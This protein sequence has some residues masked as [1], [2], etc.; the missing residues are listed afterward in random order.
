MK[1]KVKVMDMNSRT[2]YFMF[3]T[4]MLII[5]TIGIF[6]RY[7]PLSS[8]ALAFARGLLGAL[9]LCVFVKMRGQEVRHGISGKKLAALT[10]TGAVLGINWIFLFEAFRYTTV[11]TATLCYY[12]Q[13]TIVILSSPLLFQER[14]TAKKV[15]CAAVAMAGMILVSGVIGGEQSQTA[16]MKGILFGLAAA[17]FYSMVVIFNKK[18]GNVDAYEKT[19]TELFAAALVLAPYLLLT[20]NFTEI[21]MDA[22]TAVLLL[23]VGVIHTGLVYALYFGSMNDLSAQAVAVFS[24]IDPV[25][26][27]LVSALVLK[28]PVSGLEIAGACLLIGAAV[29]SE[30][31]PGHNAAA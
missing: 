23:V 11:A 16:N 31:N 21:Q 14:L 3:I 17:V 20:E 19:I 18:I 12:F 26:A 29:A 2:P 15:I 24:Y 7:I 4:S 10:V 22:A 5:G 28:E 30:L 1:H 9:S 27:V 6:R 25:V 13:P 8:P